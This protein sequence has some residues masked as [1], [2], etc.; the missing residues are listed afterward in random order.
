MGFLFTLGLRPSRTCI[1]RY[2]QY[3]VLIRNV[4]PAQARST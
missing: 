3:T 1:A 2:P 4:K